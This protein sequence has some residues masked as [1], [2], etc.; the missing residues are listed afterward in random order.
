MVD[1]D[2]LSSGYQCQFRVGIEGQAEVCVHLLSWQ[3]PLCFAII[4]VGWQWSEGDIFLFTKITS[5]GIGTKG[6]FVSDIKAMSLL[7]DVEYHLEVVQRAV[8]RYA[9]QQFKP[10]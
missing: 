4:I 9:P 3:P 7:A 1:G 8:V 5:G 6:E 2:V 10:L